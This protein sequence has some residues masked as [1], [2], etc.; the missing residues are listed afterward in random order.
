MIYFLMMAAAIIATFVVRWLHGSRLGYA[1]RALRDSEQG[2]EVMGIDTTRT[3]TIA[4]AI[5]AAMTGTVGGIWA[6]WITYIEPGSAFDIG[7][8]VKGY[9]MMILGGMGTVLGP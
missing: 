3:K 1:M 4:W 6:Y 5:S 2:A 9:I 7:I 8:S